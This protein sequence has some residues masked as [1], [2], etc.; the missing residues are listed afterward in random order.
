MKND[1]EDRAKDIREVIKELVEKC[2]TPFNLNHTGLLNI[3]IGLLTESEVNV[4]DSLEVEK[5]WQCVYLRK[6]SQKD[7]MQQLKRR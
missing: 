6:V 1:G 4:Y 5:W 3:F 2:V 7:F